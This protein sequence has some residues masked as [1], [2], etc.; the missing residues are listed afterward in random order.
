MSDTTTEKMWLNGPEAVLGN[1]MMLTD[2]LWIGLMEFVDEEMSRT[3][4]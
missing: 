4:Y 3:Q 1:G 2:G